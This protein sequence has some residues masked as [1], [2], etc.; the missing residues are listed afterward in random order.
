MD[1][2]DNALQKEIDSTSN[3]DEVLHWIPV[4]KHWLRSVALAILLYCHSSFLGVIAFFADLLDKSIS[5]GTIHNIVNEA[6]V[7]AQKVNAK[8]DLSKITD[9]AHDELFQGS[10]PV[11]TGIDLN[12][13]Y[14]YLLS[15]EDRRDAETWAI[16][17]WDLDKQ[18]LHP[19]R[20]IA[21]AGKGLRAGQALA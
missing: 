14:C 10:L 5:L 21:D 19:E 8:Q 9:G 6:I 11:L 4:T 13:F 20:I 15:V 18:G 1:K 2:A 16:L 17:L 12:S 3:N 7:E